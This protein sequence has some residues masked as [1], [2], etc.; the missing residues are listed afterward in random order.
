MKTSRQTMRNQILSCLVFV[1]CVANAIAKTPY[2][3]C[4]SKLGV[5]TNVTVSG[6]DSSPCILKK[7]SSIKITVDFVSHADVEEVKDAV[8]GIIGKIPVPFPTPH[9]NACTT[10]GIS[11][12]L[13]KGQNYTY[14]SSTPVSASY[15]DLRLIVRWAIK[16]KNG[17]Y[18]FCVLIP[19]QLK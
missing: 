7:G 13:K 4:D 10:K 6:C 2:K 14:T 5:A 3:I 15:P 9:P 11:C 19:A 1:A 18:V 17:D 12:P 16:D 8:S